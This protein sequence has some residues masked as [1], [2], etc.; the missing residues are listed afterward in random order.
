MEF[1]DLVCEMYLTAHGLRKFII[2]RIFDIEHVLSAWALRTGHQSLKN[3]QSY[4]NIQWILGV[5][6][7]MDLLSSTSNADRT[8]KEAKVSTGNDRLQ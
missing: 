8:E 3:L 1:E 5:R 4:N 6:Q 7:G 2:S